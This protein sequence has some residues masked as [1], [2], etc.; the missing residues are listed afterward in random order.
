M[1]CPE[2]QKGMVME[3][4]GGAPAKWVPCPRCQGSGI[5]YCCDGEDWSGGTKCEEPPP[6]NGKAFIAGDQPLV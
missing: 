1:I 4:E 6:D 5:A 2:C 3:A